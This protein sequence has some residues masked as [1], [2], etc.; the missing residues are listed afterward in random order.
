MNKKFLD[1]PRPINST[2]H[3]KLAFILSLIRS[4]LK[5]K[6]FD[7][8]YEYIER[9][10]SLLQRKI[11]NKDISLIDI[12]C[13]S[14]DFADKLK[15]RGLITKYTGLDIFPKPDSKDN[16]WQ[17]Y[18]Q[19]NRPADCLNFKNHDVALLID[20]LHHLQENE[21]NKLLENASKISKYIIVK[22][23]FEFG[24]LSRY[25]LILADFFGNYAYKIKIPSRYF[26]QLEWK[27]TITKLNLEEI[28]II[29]RV[30]VHKGIFGLI[31][32]EKYH[33]ISI[34]K[35]NLKP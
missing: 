25:L 1:A 7:N 33:F 19:V 2:A 12:G 10:I 34:L 11:K 32:S 14:L 30:R 3:K 9:E 27:Q 28:K 22:D 26:T 18:F 17:N 24:L 4:A 21:K 29:D 20:C 31:L 15:K 8:L 16:K 35:S 13:G 5:G 23:H 6:R